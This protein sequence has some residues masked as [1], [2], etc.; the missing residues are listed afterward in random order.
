MIRLNVVELRQ[1]LAD[2]LNRAEYQGERI[3]V[4]R[5]GKDVAAIVSIEDL[6]LL[7]RLVAEAEDR[8]DIKAAQAALS[9]SKER[10]SY[11]EFRRQMGLTDG[12][13]AAAR[14]RTTRGSAG[15]RTTGLRH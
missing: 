1:S 4:H 8:I 2:M 10:V 14:S 11:E 9:E 15:R 5:R 3:V 13:E 6:R 12:E 7:E